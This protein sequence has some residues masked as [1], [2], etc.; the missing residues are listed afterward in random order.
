M[1]GIIKYCDSCNEPI[2]DLYY[3]TIAQKF[4]LHLKCLKC[5]NCHKNL[6]KKCFILNGKFLCARDYAK[7]QL[8]QQKRINPSRICKFCQQ[9]IQ[10]RDLVIRLNEFDV[11]HLNCFNCTKC[12][13]HIDSGQKY[14]L[15]NDQLFC[16][17]HYIEEVSSI[18][19]DYTTTLSS[20]E[21]SPFS[22]N[23]ENLSTESPYPYSNSSTMSCIHERAPLVN[24]NNQQNLI[25]SNST[26]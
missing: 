25:E 24:Y 5:S 12:S 3:H 6:K 26:V 23:N 18:T 8:N 10:P 16:E 2:L 15:F 13:K 21:S 19:Y 22:N 1:D 20:T 4:Y 17:K 14:G 9:S 11:S 7:L